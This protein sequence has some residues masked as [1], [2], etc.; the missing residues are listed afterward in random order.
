MNPPK[1]YRAKLEDKQQLN[2]RFV[3]YY[4]ELVEPNELVFSA[5]QY[6]SLKV[7]EKGERRSYS[8]CSSPAVS[9][10]FELLIDHQPAGVGCTYLENLQFGQEIE[11]LAPLGIFTIVAD[12]AETSLALVATGSGIAPFR[13]MLLERL[14]VVKDTRPITLYWGMRHANTLFWE[15]EFE[16]LAQSFPNFS[17][18]PVLSQ[19]EQ[20]WPLCRGRVTDCL[21]THEQAAG[22][23]YYLCGST[24]MITDVSQTV[25]AKGVTEQRIHHEK[26]Y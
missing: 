26:F 11:L 17:F 3:Q 14:Q 25:L 8:I 21:N 12:E 24:K 15:D 18:H 13:S 5:G 23:G 7:S 16:E 2:E 4:F 6:A 19:A 22:V 20:A 10:G 9:H 1:Q